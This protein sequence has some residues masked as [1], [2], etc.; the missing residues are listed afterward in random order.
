L[1]AI[2]DFCKSKFSKAGMVWMAEM[3]HHSPCHISP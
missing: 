1:S 2:F 3:H